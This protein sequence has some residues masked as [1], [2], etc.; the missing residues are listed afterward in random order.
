MKNI[1]LF[2]LLVC[3]FLS[4]AQRSAAQC[5]VRL[6]DA[7][8]FNTD[9]YQA[10]LETAAAK[11]CAIFDTMGFA[12]QFKVYDFG[13]YL[14][15]ENTTGG[16]PEPFA[17]K[18]AEVQALSPYYLLFGKQTDKSGVYTKFWVAIK[19]PDTAQFICMTE[20]QREV[21]GKKVEK[22][23]TDK[24]VEK[25]NQFDAFQEAEIAGISEL[26]IILKEIKE[27]CL[28]RN[29]NR[30]YGCDYCNKQTVEDYFYLNEFKSINLESIPASFANIENALIID[31]SNCKINVN[32]QTDYLGHTL[33]SMVKNI[34]F[35]MSCNLVVTSNDSFCENS[36]DDVLNFSSQASITCWIHTTP[37]S[38]SFIKILWNV[39]SLYEPS[40]KQKIIEGL[41][42]SV[43]KYLGIN[44]ESCS[45]DQIGFVGPITTYYA[46]A[47]SDYTTSGPF[48]KYYSARCPSYKKFQGISENQSVYNILIY[49]FQSPSIRFNLLA[50]DPRDMMDAA[51]TKGRVNVFNNIHDLQTAQINESNSSI[52]V[53][54]GIDNENAISL[55]SKG[56]PIIFIG[57][58]Y[59]L[60]NPQDNLFPGQEFQ[61]IED[62]K[63]ID[64]AIFEA[65]NT[66]LHEFL[67][68]AE[69]ILNNINKDAIEEHDDFHGTASATS[70]SGSTIY[71]DPS[72]KHTRAYK[73]AK[74]ILIEMSK[75]GRIISNMN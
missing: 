24:Y 35:R 18:I 60:L 19:I 47:F 20:L 61:S 11:L 72:K 42:C 50:Q 56:R 54:A 51:S 25:N 3:F 37:L 36:L 2:I 22:K 38:Q 75:D 73:V 57:I 66:L 17:Q 28:G 45:F 30:M 52:T 49:T 39:D 6:A 69:N 32:G 7:S 68:H 67:A 1:A 74:E 64:L 12:E 27:C 26:Y 33:N 9:P 40:D 23:T 21:Y 29:S 15:Q 44:N 14:H 55:F 41:Y 48:V 16:Y 8:G 65:T 13:F 63:I 46:S 59:Q 10:E 62:Y 70:P 31:F 5:Y 43:Y 71:K 53:L 34:N 4:F 58:A